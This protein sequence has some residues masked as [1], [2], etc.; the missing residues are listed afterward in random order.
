MILLLISKK[1]NRR[2]VRLLVPCEMAFS[3]GYIFGPM[4]GALIIDHGGYTLL[5]LLSGLLSLATLG[6]VL[7]CA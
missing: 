1:A 5:F 7:F 6:W 2:Q 3:Q 4:L